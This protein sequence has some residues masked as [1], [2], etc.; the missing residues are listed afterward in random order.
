MAN[1][2]HSG[3]RCHS[4]LLR[5]YFH[6]V[7][8]VSDIVQSCR[9]LAERLGQFNIQSKRCNRLQRR[10]RS[11]GNRALP[12]LHGSVQVAYE[13]RL[14][15]NLAHRYSGRGRSCRVLINHDWRFLGRLSRSTPYV[16]FGFLSAQ[17]RSSCSAGHNPVHSSRVHETD[18]LL[19]LRSGRNQPSLRPSLRARIQHSDTRMVHRFYRSRLRWTTRIQHAQTRTRTTGNTKR[20]K[21]FPVLES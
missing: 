1:K 17:P 18:R 15:E 12:L 21:Q 2:L 13:G 6:V 4:F 7:G 3:C 16:V 9:Q 11:N 20:I 8:A 14:E 19:R 10:M 5:F